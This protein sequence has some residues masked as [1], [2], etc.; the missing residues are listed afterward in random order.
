MMMIVAPRPSTLLAALC[1][2]HQMWGMYASIFNQGLGHEEILKAA[3]WASEGTA[4]WNL[5]L[6]D[7]VYLFFSTEEEMLA[8]YGQTVGDDGP[9]E[10]NPYNGPARVYALT[11]D[12]EGNT[13]NENT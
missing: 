4:L 11:C 9:T 8:V 1:R 12:P 10:T 2:Q 13:H 3:P 6:E 5:T 7:S